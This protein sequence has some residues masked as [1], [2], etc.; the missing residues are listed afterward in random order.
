MAFAARYSQEGAGYLLWKVVIA[1]PLTQDVSGG[2][3]QAAAKGVGVAKRY[4]QD[5]EAKLVELLQL[6][7][8]T[9]LYAHRFV[10]QD[11]AVHR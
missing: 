9:C 2:A 3:M 8:L 1:T 7:H 5:V 10:I 6:V 11:Q 4:R